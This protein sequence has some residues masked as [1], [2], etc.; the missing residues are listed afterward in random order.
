MD[1]YKYDITT[2]EWNAIRNSNLN[3]KKREEAFDNYIKTKGQKVSLKHYFNDPQRN[4]FW[5][6][7]TYCY[8]CFGEAENTI[9]RLA[10]SEIDWDEG[11]SYCNAKD[12]NHEDLIESRTDW[13]E[14]ESYANGLYYF[15]EQ[16]K[17]EFANGTLVL[18]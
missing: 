13:D 4:D 17:R 15:V 18:A 9:E 7:K 14:M 10:K 5:R 3:S 8:K 12:H 2:D 16:L 6:D 1:I 11:L